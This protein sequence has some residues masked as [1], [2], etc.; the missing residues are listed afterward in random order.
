MKTHSLLVEKSHFASWKEE[1]SVSTSF[2]LHPLYIWG[3]RLTS[4]PLRTT[5]ELSGL[6]KHC[7]GEKCPPNPTCKSLEMEPEGG[8]TQRGD[9]WSWVCPCRYSALSHHC[10]LAVMTQT[11]SSTFFYTSRHNVLPCHRPKSIRVNQL[12]AET[13]LT[14]TQ[15]SLQRPRP[16][17]QPPSVSVY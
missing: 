6:V 17:S 2:D 14:R 7:G 3:K 1:K 8:A 5:H 16:H 15:I 13:P 12:W 4:W 10:F 9:G 11:A